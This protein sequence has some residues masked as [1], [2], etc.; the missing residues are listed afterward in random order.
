MKILITNDDGIFSPGIKALVESLHC[1]GNI[2]VVAP[3]Q[4][5]SGVGHGIT[6]NHPLRFE[7]IQL[8][9]NIDQS[10]MVSGTPADCVKLAIEGLDYQPDIVISGIN[11]GTNLGTDFFYS[12]TISAAAEGAFNNIPAIAISLSNKDSNKLHLD[13]A[14]YFLK[15][16]LTKLQIPFR[17]GKLLNINVPALTKDDVQGIKVTH[18]GISRYRNE[19]EQRLDPRGKPYY[20]MK[21]TLISD[22]LE[23]ADDYSA[24]EQGFVSVTP[25]KFDLTDQVLLQQLQKELAN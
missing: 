1:F 13:T 19:F 12:G 4:E 9:P 2:M 18:L 21:A 11:V 10:Y 3:N 5:R 7:Q 22:S 14:T 24:V 25:I 16:I 6:V 17:Q 20:W 23:N 15:E 8:F